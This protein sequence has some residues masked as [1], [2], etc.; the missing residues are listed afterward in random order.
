MVE[1]KKVIDTKDNLD[2]ILLPF[3]VDNILSREVRIAEY[4]AR[5]NICDIRVRNDYLSIAKLIELISEGYNITTGNFD[6]KLVPFFQ[7]VILIDYWYGNNPNFKQELKEKNIFPTF[8]IEHEDGGFL[9]DKETA[10]LGYCIN[11]PI[12][13][14]T[15]VDNFYK[16]LCKI[17]FNSACCDAELPC[18][19]AY[20][21]GTIT[22]LTISNTVYFPLVKE[23]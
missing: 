3:E 8:I 2:I 16:Y 15:L 4:Y 13:N 10:V 21:Y 14:E 20:D 19:D 7:Q 12:E 1:P 18:Y 22:N 11:A 23:M 17:L 9:A 6:K 5:N